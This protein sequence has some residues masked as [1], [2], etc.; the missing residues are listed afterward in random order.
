MAHQEDRHR[1]YIHP[2]ES[3]GLDVRVGGG[4]NER[5]G[6]TCKQE[7]IEIGQPLVLPGLENAPAIADERPGIDKRPRKT[8]AID[9]CQQHDLITPGIH[10]ATDV[11][12]PDA[13]P[14]T[15]AEG[16][17]DAIEQRIGLVGTFGA[18][19]AGQLFPETA[20]DVEHVHLGEAAE[21]DDE[22]D[23]RQHGNAH[24]LAQ[25]PGNGAG[26]L[27]V[28]AW[29]Q[30]RPQHQPHG[31]RQHEG[32]TAGGDRHHH[33]DAQRDQQLGAH[34][35]DGQH[36]KHRAGHEEQRAIDVHRGARI[37]VNQVDVGVLG[38][39]EEAHRLGAAVQEQ[40][41]EQAHAGRAEDGVVLH[42]PLERVAL[43]GG[44]HAAGHQDPERG[45]HD[46]DEKR[47]KQRLIAG[48]V[49]QPHHQ[50]QQRDGRRGRVHPDHPHEGG[51]EVGQRPP[52][53]SGK[54]QKAHRHR[55]DGVG[56]DH[57]QEQQYDEGPTET[58]RQPGRSGVILS[59]HLAVPH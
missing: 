8:D 11:I 6:T 7:D 59:S 46:V 56:H 42:H 21:Q 29:T 53:R 35:A 33:Q 55:L 52:Q 39:D 28:D 13:V 50:I 45:R 47:L 4:S 12:D 41:E 37:A 30:Q 3:V 48:A 26:A 51:R 58:D 17:D 15:N 24:L 43:E 19:T 34:L 31:H 22:D 10:L 32:R 38:L 23:T 9:G 40:I 2:V 44:Q 36:G 54:R 57:R 14:G 27:A 18:A 5:T 25:R 49:D 1:K 20:N 16:G